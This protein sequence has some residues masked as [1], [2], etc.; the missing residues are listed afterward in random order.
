VEMG[1]PANMTDSTPAMTRTVPAASHF[2]PLRLTVI[3]AT[4][5]GADEPEPIGAPHPGHAAA[6]SD[7]SFPHSPHLIIATLPPAF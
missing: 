4:V 2:P 6:L 7:T 1:G 5:C 3:L